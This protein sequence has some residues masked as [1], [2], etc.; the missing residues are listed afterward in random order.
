MTTTLEHLNPS[1]A[2]AGVKPSGSLPIAPTVQAIVVNG[3][4]IVDPQLTPIIG[5]D[6]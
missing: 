6:A 4:P 2:P 5:N 1:Q 3:V